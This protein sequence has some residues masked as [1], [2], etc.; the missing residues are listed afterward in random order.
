MNNWLL[1]IPLLTCFAGWFSVWIITRSDFHPKR[2]V[3]LLGL[4]WQGIFPKYSAS[5]I[6]DIAKYA[7]NE[8]S[9]TDTLAERISNPEALEK[10]MPLIEEHIDD[11][12][13]K[14]LT[15]QMPMIGM[16]IGEK[17]IIQLKTVFIN[18]LKE[19]FPVIITN[20]MGN[21]ANDFNVEKI[22]TEKL[23]NIDSATLNN[24]LEK[25]LSKQFNYARFI[26][27]SIGLTMGIFQFLIIYNLK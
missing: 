18:E 25:A 1:L 20:Y 4:R 16:L 11:F 6:H 17:T 10:I 26:G 27:F 9:F 13:R 2:E 5:I 23:N 15:E 14:K 21:L 24:S 3:L 7:A 8:L 19:L 12:L 22:I